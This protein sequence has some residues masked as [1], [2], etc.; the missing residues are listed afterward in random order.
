MSPCNC[1][2]WKATGCSTHR[3]ARRHITSLEVVALATS[4]PPGTRRLRFCSTRSSGAPDMADPATAGLVLTGV[5][6]AVKAGGALAGGNAAQVSANY[7]AAQLDQNAMGA[8]AAGQRSMF[9]TQRKTGLVQ[10]N[11]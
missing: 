6:T 11:L 8:V 3:A 7:K 5:G 9:E 2:C 4:E 1:S 10:S